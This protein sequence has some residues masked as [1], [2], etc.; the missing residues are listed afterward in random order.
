MHDNKEAIVPQ[1]LL[2]PINTGQYELIYLICHLGKSAMEA[3]RTG[4][5]GPKGGIHNGWL[6]NS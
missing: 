6:Y 2:R 4:K 3:P 5:K 1:L